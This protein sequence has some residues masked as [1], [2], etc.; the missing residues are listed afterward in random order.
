MMIGAGK[1]TVVTKPQTRQETGQ[2]QGQTQEGVDNEK[3]KK[4]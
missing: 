1:Y 4:K 3:V 2:G